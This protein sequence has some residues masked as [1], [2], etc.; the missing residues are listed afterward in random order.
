MA[1]NHPLLL[2]S[3]EGTMARNHPLL[4]V[5]SE[6]TMARN[7]PLLLGDL[8]YQSIKSLRSVSKERSFYGVN[9]SVP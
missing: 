2:V 5:S 3:S 8:Q 6:G 1:R 4:L 9:R 7:H